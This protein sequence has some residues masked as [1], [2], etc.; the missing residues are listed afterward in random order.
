MSMPPVIAG[1]PFATPNG[2]P[3]QD[4]FADLTVRQQEILKLLLQGLPNKVIARAL[5]ISPNTVKVHVHAIF[6]ELKVHSRM[7]LAMLFWAPPRAKRTGANEAHH[8]SSSRIGQG[9]FRF[10]THREQS[11]GLVLDHDS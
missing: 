7:D 11:S 5:G 10:D 6:R 8:V 1:F 2:T 3:E 9:V 4:L